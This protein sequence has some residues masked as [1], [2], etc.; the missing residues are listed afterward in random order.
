M[1]KRILI[2]ILVASL[3][4]NIAF[5]ASWAGYRFSQGFADDWGQ[6]LPTD[7]KD[8]IWCPLHRSLNVTKEQW[9]QLEPRLLEF[10]NTSQSICEQVNQKRGEMIDI[11]SSPDPERQTIYDKQKEI[12][13]AQ[14]KMQQ[15]VIEHL[16]FEKSVLNSRQQEEFFHLFRRQCRFA[17]GQNAGRK[18]SFS[19]ILNSSCEP[20]QA[21]S[22]NEQED[23]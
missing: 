7:E 14:Q 9:Q 15:L 18:H 23:R 16:L 11:I 17:P 6:V 22:E 8:E 12:L 21:D 19:Q 1:S 4:L 3:A 2:F 10:R 5:V 20:P 13:A